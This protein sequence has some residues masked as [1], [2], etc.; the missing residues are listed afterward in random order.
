MKERKYRVVIENVQFKT[1][2]KPGWRADVASEYPGGW[3]S[4]LMEKPWTELMTSLKSD[5]QSIVDSY[6][7]FIKA[8]S[9]SVDDW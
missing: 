5:M 8:P 7:K 1:S 2:S 9:G 4:A 3:N 6:E